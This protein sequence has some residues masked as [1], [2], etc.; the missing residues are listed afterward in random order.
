MRK[1]EAIHIGAQHEIVE[2]RAQRSVHGVQMLRDPR[3]LGDVVVVRI[4]DRR[5][6]IQQFAHDRAA[7]RPLDCDVHFGGGGGQCVA[8]H[9][10][11]DR[12]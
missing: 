1:A 12:F 7:A 10:H 8:D 4:E 6:I 2:K 9:L 11:G 3:G 5:R